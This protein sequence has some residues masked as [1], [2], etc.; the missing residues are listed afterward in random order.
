MLRQGMTVREAAQ[1]WVREFNAI[2]DHV[3]ELLMRYSDMEEIT[4][5]A[6]GN[7]VYVD[8]PPES[9]STSSEGEVV[10][11]LPD[12]DVYLVTMDDGVSVEVGAED[13]EVQR[14]DSL[15]MWGTLWAFGDALDNWWLE[16]DGGLRIMADCGFRI[17]RQ[18]DYEY[19]FG[20]D[21]AGYDFYS[22]HFIPLY[23]K[24]GLEW[25]D[26]NAKE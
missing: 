5:I 3:A 12:A 20:I 7:R 18:E 22:A 9:E 16:K 10:N 2:P 24:R 25:H 15:P 26:P 1:E 14:Y 21:G 8:L 17:Y 6:I 4:P 23:K 19:I 11:S 13:L